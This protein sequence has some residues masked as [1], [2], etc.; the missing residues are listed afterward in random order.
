[1]FS[2]VIWL[3]APVSESARL[4]FEIVH[5]EQHVRA[6]TLLLSCLKFSAEQSK[7][8]EKAHKHRKKQ[9]TEM[10]KILG[11]GTKCRTASFP[12]WWKEGAIVPKSLRSKNVCETIRNEALVFGSFLGFLV[13]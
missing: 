7:T 13:S 1:M 6:W 12:G 3:L 11:F 4:W 2:F 5:Q 10:A 9:H 8:G